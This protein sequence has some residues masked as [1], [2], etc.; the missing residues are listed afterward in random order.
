MPTARR[1]SQQ[2][3]TLLVARSRCYLGAYEALSIER[4]IVACRDPAL[5]EAGAHSFYSTLISLVVMGLMYSGKAY[6]Q[7]VWK[8]K[9]SIETLTSCRT[10]GANGDIIFVLLFYTGVAEELP[11]IVTST[12]TPVL[13]FLSTRH[14]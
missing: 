14:A 13:I 5:A 4:L 2:R 9:A 11:H 7:G 12:L 10:R 6:M 3:S 1:R 8:D